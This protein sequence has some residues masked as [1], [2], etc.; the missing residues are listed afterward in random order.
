MLKDVVETASELHS[1]QTSSWLERRLPAGLPHSRGKKLEEGIDMLARAKR[2]EIQWHTAKRCTP[3]QWHNLAGD[4]AIPLQLETAIPTYSNII[5]FGHRRIFLHRHWKKEHWRHDPATAIV[6]FPCSDQAS[7]IAAAWKVQGGL[8]WLLQLQFCGPLRIFQ[9]TNDGGD[10]RR[11]SSIRSPGWV[12][13][14][15]I[16]KLNHT[17]GPA[18]LRDENHELVQEIGSEW[19]RE[20]Q[21]DT[22]TGV[23]RLV[24]TCGKI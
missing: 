4:Q 5:Y 16:H 18:E 11:C 6:G 9:G 19:Q 10:M 17:E 21:N 8:P 12:I 22:N 13:T 3:R 1:H 7:G 23:S 14:I 20:S 15:P 24:K 2:F